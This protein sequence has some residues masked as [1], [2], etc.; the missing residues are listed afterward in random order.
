LTEFEE[1]LL[2]AINRIGKALEDQT[3]FMKLRAEKED[4]EDEVNP[5]GAPN[6]EL[7]AEAL[8]RIEK[9]FDIQIHPNPDEDS[10]VK[11]V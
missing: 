6:E 4:L 7:L 8:G 2:A 3:Q 9:R 10:E 5:D 1:K 11:P